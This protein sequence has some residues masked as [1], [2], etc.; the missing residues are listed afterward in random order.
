ML[1]I[2]WQ[3]VKK[4]TMT[5]PALKVVK[6]WIE[7]GFR[8]NDARLVSPEI[9][10]YVRHWEELW[11]QDEVVLKGS[12]TVIPSRLRERVLECLHAA[13]QG[14][15]QMQARADLAV[16]WP[17]IREDMEQ[18]RAKC[19]VCRRNAPSNPSMPPHNPPD[20]QF[21]FQ[22]VCGDYM[23]V[24]GVPYLVIVDRLTGWPSVQRSRNNDS[25]STGLV[26]LLREMFTTFGI[27]EELTS[28]GGP[29]FM[30]H[31]VK[32]FL[33][34]YG[35]RHRVSS[36]GNPHSNQRAEVGIKSMKRLIRGNLGPSGSLDDDS[37]AQATLQYHN[38]PLQ[39]TGLLPAVALFGYPIRDFLPLTRKTYAPSIQWTKKIG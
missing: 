21:P 10:P 16:F 18:T 2:T 17:G 33:A 11:V 22:Q 23:T 13:H 35:V 3:M 34:K 8:P 36:V 12:R 15:T 5:D 24:N 31:E 37:F 9:A 1:T 4:A 20:L 38:T 28:D 30:A 6:D 39:S 32:N 29:E 26:K 27:A 14:V 25:G 19:A 7:Q